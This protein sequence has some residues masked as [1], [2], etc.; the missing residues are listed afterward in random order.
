MCQ[1]GGVQNQSIPSECTAME[2]YRAYDEKS[3]LNAFLPEK[4]FA[5]HVIQCQLL[6]AS[7]TSYLYFKL[8]PLLDIFVFE[9]FSTWN[10]L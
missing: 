1:S 5:H 9:L 7:Q 8:V 10:A 3:R 2:M 6:K 4:L